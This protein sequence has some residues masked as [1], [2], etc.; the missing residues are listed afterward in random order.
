MLFK[1]PS[2]KACQI[3]GQIGLCMVARVPKIMNAFLGPT[4]HTL[5][6]REKHISLTVLSFGTRVRYKVEDLSHRLC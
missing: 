2:G 3:S 4:A 6:T 5:D 1:A